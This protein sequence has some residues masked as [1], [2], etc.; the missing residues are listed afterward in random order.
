MELLLNLIWL[1]LAL[2]SLRA[3]LRASARDRRQFLLGLG[4]LLCALMLLLPAI[5]ITDD[6]HVDFFAVEDSSAT[7][8]A[9]SQVVHSL[10]L[11]CAVWIGTSLLALLF[12]VSRRKHWHPLLGL[13][14]CVISSD[15]PR[16]IATRAPPCCSV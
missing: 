12:A 15:F 7:K 6:L 5:S 14:L 1:V 2:G 10:P 16:F 4:A 11:W 13:L 9:M 8:R 3:Y